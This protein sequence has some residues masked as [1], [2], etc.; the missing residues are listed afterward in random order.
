LAYLFVNFAATAKF[1]LDIEILI[2]V[3]ILH[4]QKGGIVNLAIFVWADL[5]NGYQAFTS[6]KLLAKYLV[7]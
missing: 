4:Q 6:F 3:L 1:T 5:S 2:N 7:K